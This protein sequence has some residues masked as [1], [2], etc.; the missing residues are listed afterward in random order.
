[1]QLNVRQ[2]GGAA[3]LFEALAYIAGF[4]FMFTVLQPALAGAATP[5]H[6]LAAILAVVEWY[7]AWN[8]IIY[9]LFGAV[10]VLLVVALHERL[11]PAAPA[12]T[13]AASAFGLIWAGLVIATGMI[14]NVALSVVGDLHGVNPAGATLAWQTLNVVQEGLGGGVELVGGCWVLLVSVAALR[15]GALPAWLNDLGSAIGVAGILTVIP[16]LGELG[17]VFGL[18]Q[19]VWFT[20]LGIVMLR[21]GPAG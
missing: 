19:I 6:K 18:G 10:L 5:A 2:L 20:W 1:M 8:I 15:T 16:P 4:V 17:A 9:V 12:L 11:A 14:A 21:P 13:K 7:K 3:A